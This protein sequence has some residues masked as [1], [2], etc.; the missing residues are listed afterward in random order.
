[1]SPINVSL[2][3]LIQ[4]FDDN[5]L[6]RSYYLDK[7]TG[8]VFNLLEDH[9]DPETEEMAWEIEADGGRRYISIPK[10]SLEEEIAER[11][12]FVNDLKEEELK[13]KLTEMLETDR[14]NGRRFT[15]FIT[16]ERQA[17]DQ[18]RAYR[19]ARSRERAHR[20]IESLEISIRLMSS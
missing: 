2:D 1:M 15:D 12:S 7:T 3:A 19:R 13:K 14:S 18:W 11:E 6:E 16:K 9:S 5:S 8:R 10:M 20:W 17:R 4:A